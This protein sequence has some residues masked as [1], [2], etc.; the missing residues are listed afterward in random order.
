MFF[1]VR[2]FMRKQIKEDENKNRLVSKRI[3]LKSLIIVS[4][5]LVLAWFKELGHTWAILVWSGIISSI[6]VFAL[7]FMKNKND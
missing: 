7:F 3:L 2:L 6:L 5:F 1:V 4:S